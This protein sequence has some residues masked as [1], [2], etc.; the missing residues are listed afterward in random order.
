MAHLLEDVTLSQDNT[1]QCPNFA[2]QTQE[3]IIEMLIKNPFH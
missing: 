2:I 1:V 3:T